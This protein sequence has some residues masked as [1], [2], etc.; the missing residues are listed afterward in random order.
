MKKLLALTLA[1][2]FIGVGIAS[3]TDFTI[4]GDYYARG[5]YND[6]KEGTATNGDSYGVYDHEMVLNTTWQIS[7][8]TKVFARFEVRDES[9]AAGTNATETNGADDTNPETNIVNE[10]LY[11]QHTFANGLTVRTGLM[12]TSSWATDFG[13]D[14]TEAYRVMFIK[15]TGM[16]QVILFTEKPQG[17]SETLTADSDIDVYF[18]G[19]V[20]KVNDIV[21]TPSVVYVNYDPYDRVQYK[22]DM[23]AAGTIGNVGFES[24][25]IIQDFD[26]DTGAGTDYTVYGAYVNVWT[27]LNALKLGAAVA[28]GSYDDDSGNGFEFNDD[29]ECA[30]A[31][32]MGDEALMGGNDSIEAAT[33]LVLYGSY[34]VS[35]KFTMSAYLGYADSNVD[36]ELNVNGD[37]QYDG[38]NIWEVN[39]QGSY[40][41]TDNVTY[42]AGAATSQTEYD[43]A[44]TDPDEAIQIYH[45]L[46]FT[47]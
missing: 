2:M 24:E 35:E 4:T 16:G 36:D 19:L 18:A 46:A 21:L 17:G 37:A 1:M 12:G 7:P 34:A 29:F 41:I 32:L 5:Q 44:F 8:Y 40:K 23:G 28:Y 30:G 15:N 42:S 6:N 25:V 10:Y 9:W 27:Q 31:M 47:F 38:A 13:N 39:V 26:Y 45:K 20:T 11:G 14:G 3:A 43:G 33:L 22:F